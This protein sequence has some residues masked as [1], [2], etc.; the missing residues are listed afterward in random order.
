MPNIVDLIVGQFRC[1]MTGQVEN[2]CVTPVVEIMFD[3]HD[4]KA[5]GPLQFTAR[6]V[7]QIRGIARAIGPRA[8]KSQFVHDDRMPTARQEQQRI[9]RFDRIALPGTIGLLYFE[10]LLGPFAF[11][12]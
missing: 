2:R 4:L 9:R 11:R 5:D 7:R 8:V 12:I 1:N 3:V 10:H 6:K